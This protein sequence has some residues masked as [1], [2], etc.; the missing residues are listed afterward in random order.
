M[1]AVVTGDADDRVR[2]QQPARLR[3]R[4]VRLADMRSITAI[5]RRQV[6]PIVDD[7]SDIMRVRD[8]HQHIDRTPDR[9]VVDLFQS[10]LQTGDI[11]AAQRRFKLLGERDRLQ[12]GGGHEIEPASGCFARSI[13]LGLCQPPAAGGVEIVDTG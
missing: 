1:S 6:R 10:K 7:E 3:I 12:D 8:R 13:G 4:H 9:R 2:S 11:T 5:A